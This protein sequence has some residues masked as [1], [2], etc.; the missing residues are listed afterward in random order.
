MDTLE[1]FN[2]NFDGKKPK[3]KGLVIGLIVAVLA[4]MVALVLV[5][6]L[7][8]SNP[9]IIFSKAID[10][11]LAVDLENHDSVKM[12]TEI[13]ASLDLEDTT[14]EEE[15]A[16]I[17]KLTIKAGVQMDVEEKQEIVDL[18]ID[19]DNKAVI[20]ARVYYDDGEMYTYLEGLFDRYIEI[21]MDEETKTQF[22]ELFEDP[23]SEGQ[24][25]NAEKAI[26]IA[27][28]ELKNQIKE[29]GEFEKKKDEIEIGKDE[30]KATKT[31][32]TISAKKMDKIVANILSN[33]AKNDEFLDCFEESPKEWLKEMAEQFK[34]SNSSSEAYTKVSLYTKGLLNNNLVAIRVEMSS[35][36]EDNAVVLKVVKE[37]KNVYAYDASM[38]E[39]EVKVDLVKGR[40]EIEKD[41]DTKKEQSGT[42]VITADVIEVGSAK[43]EIDYAVEYDEGIDKINTSN[44]VN[45]N[46]LTEADTQ[47]MLTKLMERP[48]IGDIIS[49]LMNTNVEDDFRVD[50]DTETNVENT[51]TTSQNEVKDEYSGYSVTYS[52]PSNFVYG[53]YSSNDMKFYELENEDYSY[54]NTTVCLDWY[55]ESEYIDEEINWD[56]E[57]WNESTDYKNVVLSEVKTINVGDKQFKYQILSYESNF[58]FSSESKYQKAYIWYVLDDEYLFTVQLEATDTELTEDIMK[59]FLNINVTELN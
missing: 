6:F 19:Y 3:K 24:L 30:V 15:L 20:D 2:E 49:N 36:E 54:I 10:E 39:D 21:D 17:E 22:A 38:K 11:L 51:I 28:D 44:S 9:K 42:L 12:N 16:E 7:V 33:L 40:I 4:I 23:I 5:Y 52:V 35:G 32:V 31:T 37:D 13:K 25:K 41:K 8:L 47:A 14:Y 57:Y 58:G 50:P 53:N 1:Q 26:Q 45:M 43:L 27:K 56:Y 46:D 55:T 59:G 18:G 48:L 34:N 29:N